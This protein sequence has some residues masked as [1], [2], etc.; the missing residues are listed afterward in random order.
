MYKLLL[1]LNYACVNHTYL[2][3]F[4]RCKI[5]FI[6][7]AALM[8]TN[9]SEAEPRR[10]VYGAVDATVPTDAVG[11]TDAHPICKIKKI[12]MLANVSMVDI[13]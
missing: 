3:V 9:T 11:A 1:M 6:K 12:Y 4:T 2:F 8:K 10:R 7:R 5:Y 13:N